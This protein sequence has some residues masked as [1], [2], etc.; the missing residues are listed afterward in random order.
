M[1]IVHIDDDVDVDVDYTSFVRT[2]LEPKR[3]HENC[4]VIH[5]SDFNLKILDKLGDSVSP[6]GGIGKLASNLF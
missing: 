3:N 4:I 6:V 1:Y 2:N 5:G